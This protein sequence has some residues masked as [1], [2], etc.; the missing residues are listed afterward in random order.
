MSELNAALGLLQLQHVDEAITQR[1]RIDAIVNHMF[2]L[3]RNL[4]ERL[5]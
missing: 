3:N 1:K 4:Y 5:S 2:Q